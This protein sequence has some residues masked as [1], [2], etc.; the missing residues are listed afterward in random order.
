MH[1]KSLVNSSI[2]IT[3]GTGSFGHA[4][5]NYLCNSVKKI[6]RLVIYSRDELKQYKMAQKFPV[7]KYPFIRFFL[8]DVR[9]DKRLQR[10]LNGI[11]IIKFMPEIKGGKSTN[12]LSVILIE[13]IKHE[14]INEIILNFEE[15]NIEIRPVWKPMHLQP[16]FKNVPFY[17]KKN[18]AISKY[19]FNQG[20]CLPSGSNLAKYEIDRIIKLL[21]DQI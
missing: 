18:E 6:K 16:L 9:D 20:L 19:L 1:I 4:M 2:L 12:W 7:S 5:T 17:H 8:G 11:D 21:K 3:G 14:K 13:N 15:Q 10:A